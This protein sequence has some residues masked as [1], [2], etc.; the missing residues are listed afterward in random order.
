[1]MTLDTLLQDP[2]FPDLLCVGLSAACLVLQGMFLLGKPSKQ[3]PFWVLASAGL[4]V[5]ALVVRSFTASYWAL[6]NMYESLLSLTLGVQLVWLWLYARY[7]SLPF[8]FSGTVLLCLLLLGIAFYMP[9]AINPI[10]PALISYWRAI[11]VPIIIMSYALFFVSFVGSAYYLWT[12]YTGKLKGNDTD[13]LAEPLL[14]S[15]AQATPTTS[16]I[17]CLDLTEQCVRLGFALLAIG[18]LLGGLWANEAWGTYWNWDPKET[19]ALATLLAYGVYLHLNYS[20]NN[21]PVL[22][23]WV[24]V[25]AFALLLVTYLGVNVLGLGL[26]SY[27]Q[28]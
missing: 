12:S 10:Q 13:P 14:D 8:F 3:S 25:G 20:T 19:M 9:H 4:L 17:L 28:F 26:H 16:A 22:L 2:A 11:H 5:A 15:V 6:T 1:M 7:K 21:G 27:G 23:S 24:S 18:I